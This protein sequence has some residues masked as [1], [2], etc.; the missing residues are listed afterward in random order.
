MFLARKHS[1]QIIFCDY[2][3]QRELNF[4]YIFSRIEE[5]EEYMQRERANN[6]RGI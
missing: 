5:I 4:T 6:D 1:V 2:I 3:V